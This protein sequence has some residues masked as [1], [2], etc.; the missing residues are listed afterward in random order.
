[1]NIENCGWSLVAKYL[2]HEASEEES[3][4]VEAWL[5]SSDVNHES[6][7]HAKQ[8]LE[9][10]EIYLKSRQFNTKKAWSTIQPSISKQKVKTI[11]QV[12]KVKNKAMKTILRY[13]AAIIIFA[14]VGSLVY[15]FGSPE[16]PSRIEQVASL[17]KQILEEVLLPDGSLVT[18]NG[19]SKLTYPS[20]FEGETREVTIMGEAFFDVASNQSKPFII[21]A[22]QAKIKVVGTS[23]NVFAYPE[24][25]TVEV[26]VKTG[27]VE[28]SHISKK[29]HGKE[30]IVLAPGEK[31][32]LDKNKNTLQK[33]L[34]ENPNYTAW[35]THDLIFKNTMMDDVIDCLN[36]SYHVDIQA[37]SPEIYDLKWTAHFTDQSID[38]ILEVIR[39]TFNLDLS[40]QEDTYILTSRN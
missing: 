12:S 5:K 6:F 38:Y 16:N 36:K 11:G 24:E 39:L 32:T 21:V 40:S 25:E 30:Q 22:G 2:N 28:V 4:I 31:V 29:P 19:N 17:D 20:V 26:V 9:K 33:S 8:V 3:K 13:A 14:A 1:M 27:K 37:N 35:F 23:F 15:Y 18:L 7:Q 34:N 10:S